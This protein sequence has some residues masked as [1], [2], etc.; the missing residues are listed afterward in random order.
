[1]CVAMGSPAWVRPALTGASQQ[2]DTKW[3]DELA[4]ATAPALAAYELHRLGGCPHLPRFDA[5]R[6]TLH[7]GGADVTFGNDEFQQSIRNLMPTGFV[8]QARACRR[9]SQFCRAA[10]RVSVCL[11]LPPAAACVHRALSH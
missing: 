3:D 7:G 1:M 5:V 11:S 9:C 8:F 2:L 4:Y 6:C 10:P